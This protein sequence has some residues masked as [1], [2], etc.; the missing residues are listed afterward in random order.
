MNLQKRRNQAIRHLISGCI[1]LGSIVSQGLCAEALY[2]QVPA[3]IH[4]SSTIS[5]GKHTMLEIAEIARKNDIKAVII[6]DFYFSCI[7]YGIWPLRNVISR[8]K[9]FNSVFT[10]GI[11]KYLASVRDVQRQY[12]GMVFIPA[13]ETAPFYYW[14][15]SVFKN[16]LTLHDWHKHIL[17]IGL[18]SSESYRRLPV[19]G[20]SAGLAMPF[21]ASDLPRLWP[22]LV[23]AAGIA[24]L[25]ASGIKY[26]TCYAGLRHFCLVP[27]FI[28]GATLILIG[29]LFTYNNFLVCPLKFTQYQSS[30]GVAP[31]QHL[32]DYVKQQGGLTFWAH[33]EAEN[34]QDL[35][36]L[37]VETREY[38]GDLMRTEGYTGFAVFYEGYKK[39]GCAG[40]AWDELLVS[41]CKG[42]RNTPVWAI[43]GLSFDESGSLEEY[44]K[45][46][47]TV[48]LVR[49]LS[50]E[51]VLGALAS[52]RM[53]VARGSN[54]GGFVLDEF[55]V[56]ATPSNG[57]QQR[58][59]GETLALKGRTAVII[60]KGRFLHGQ[61]FP[62]KIQLI[63]DAKVIKTF[64]AASSFDIEYLD[65]TSRGEGKKSYYR[66]EFQ[67]RDLTAITNPIFTDTRLN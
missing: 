25:V 66:V 24:F 31:Y 50:K 29:M 67:G 46:L 18:D 6:T 22:L 5:E 28:A 65:E 38:T 57:L 62:L 26:Q 32:I 2:I 64:E 48:L 14:E 12:P 61:E 58:T 55:S 42:T 3:A 40:C 13:V 19:T 7:E 52:G 37:E 59:M 47:R 9:E 51:E 53:Y 8:R 30:A 60:I 44:L 34:R 33:P 15:G 21:A 63:K 39:I 43:G 35:G 20:N 11:D 41:Y 49:R 36:M 27:H 16:N 54:S 4:I 56:K 10:Y 1:A 17:V 45:D 23:I